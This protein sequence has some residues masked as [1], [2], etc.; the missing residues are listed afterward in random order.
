MKTKMKKV[1]GKV[2]FVEEIK[3]IGNS[4]YAKIPVELLEALNIKK[5]KAK[6]ES[7]LEWSPTYKQN[8][9]PI[10]NPKEG[11]R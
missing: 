4:Y 9:I 5:H 3:K 2:I 1:N 7:M 10:W 6:F 11:N 8:Y